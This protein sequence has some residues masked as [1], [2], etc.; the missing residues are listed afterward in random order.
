LALAGACLGPSSRAIA[1]DVLAAEM[2]LPEPLAGEHRGPKVAAG[3]SGTGRFAGALFDAFD[4]ERAMRTVH[5]VDGFY[6]APANDG[7]EAVIDFLAQQLGAAGYGSAAGFEIAMLETPLTGSG[8]QPE[9]RIPAQAW[10]PV[11]A[12]LTLRRA[13]EE[14]VVL[15]AFSAPGDVDRV[16]LPINAPT[17][18][19]DG[20]IASSLEELGAGEVLVMD[21]PP[22]LPVLMRAQAAGA[23]A[24]LSASLEHYNVDPGGSERH[25]DAIQF[26]SLPVGTSIPVAMI[27]PRS[28]ETIRRALEADPEA[29]IA[30]RAEV[31]F[32]ARPLRTLMAR[33]VG[34]DRPQEAVVVG[35]HVQE[36]GACDNASGVAGLCESAVGLV[37]LIQEGRLERPSRS[38]VFLWGDEFRQTETWLD[39][40][41]LVPVAGLSSDMTGESAATGAI[42][43]LER[44]PDPGAVEPLAPDE[45]TLWGKAE[46]DATALA[47]NGLAVI[48]RSALLDVAAEAGGWKTA[49]H[50]YEGGSDHDVFIARDIPAALFWHFTDFTYHTSMD[51][52]EF[53]DP[54]EMRRTG[55]ALM[56]TALALADPRPGDLE[57]YLATLNLELNM[58][59]A[60]AESAKQ[61]A[62]TKLWKDWCHG[63]RQWLRAECLRIPAAE[64]P[65]EEQR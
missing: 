39:Q 49:E 22:R 16:M 31:R 27:S 34:S 59:V 53:V 25:L 56:T 17:A 21:A 60:A 11:S 29:R 20:T 5:F 52:T 64:L 38:L 51:R 14:E 62:L 55:T 47:P 61:G 2:P 35:S 63:A 8:P 18:D 42:A 45:H 57:R 13:A 23:V 54:H 1:R 26:R 12:R 41:D 15:H 4:E 50:P 28:L 37:R 3:E 10:T 43:L 65:P 46:I 19:V 48:A 7:Y 33:V 40:T 9:Q 30:F 58:R 44:M 32:D 36:P 24:V 6:R